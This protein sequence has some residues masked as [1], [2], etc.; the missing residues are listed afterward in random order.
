M[1]IPGGAFFL[2]SSI[3]TYSE[4]PHPHSRYNKTST[5]HSITAQGRL[6]D[7]YAYVITT[8]NREALPEGINEIYGEEEPFE[9]T[10]LIDYTSLGIKIG[11]D[12]KLSDPSLHVDL[13]A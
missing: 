13:F 10:S 3:Q 8:L 4:S 7:G 11:F 9:I 1:A 12:E 6:A 2:G 5:T